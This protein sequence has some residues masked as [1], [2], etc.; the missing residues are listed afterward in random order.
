[1]TA[2]RVAAAGALIAACGPAPRR[3][4]AAEP[5]G[6]H[7]LCADEGVGALSPTHEL[8]RGCGTDG[9]SCDQRCRDGDPHACMMEAF[10]LQDASRDEESTAI[11]TR[12]CHLGLAIGC[13]NVGAHLWL[14]HQPAS[15]GDTRCA[16]RLFDLACAAG[17]PYGCGMIGRMLASEA[18]TPELQTSARAFFEETCSRL[19]GASCVMYAHHLELGELGAADLGEVRE[20]MQRACETGDTSACGHDTAASRFHD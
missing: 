18:V 5:P 4:V 1:M 9:T 19:G 2:L 14:K 17:E 15:P 11:F 12:A 20:L 8:D 7:G 10:R 16:R 3:P 6:A 13:T